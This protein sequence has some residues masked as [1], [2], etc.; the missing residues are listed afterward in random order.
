M[1]IN[2]K[3]EIYDRKK[4]P[5]VPK[6]VIYGVRGKHGLEVG[7]DE[8]EMKN[9][10]SGIKSKFGYL[11][12]YLKD[13]QIVDMTL[14]GEFHRSLGTLNNSW[15]V[16]VLPNDRLYVWYGKEAGSHIRNW[17]SKLEKMENRGK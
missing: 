12:R 9:Q 5:A 7:I 1:R 13:K 11:K 14:K 8:M 4:Q 10:R 15:A 6:P 2:S 3:M 17:N 16:S